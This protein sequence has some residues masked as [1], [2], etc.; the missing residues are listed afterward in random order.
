[1]LNVIAD[2]R[3][4]VSGLAEK[5]PSV[6]VSDIILVRESG[7]AESRWFEGHVH[8]VLE[9]SVYLQFNRSFHCFSGQRFDVRFALNRTTY[10]R[11]HQAMNTAYSEKRTLFPGPEEVV[12]LQPPTEE[13]WGEIRTVERMI[14]DNKPQMEAIATIV[15]RPKGSPPFVVFG[16]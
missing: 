15:N 10:R 6:I 13:Q 9:K 7:S 1:L 8:R 4:E 2:Y 14:M 3:L 11:M 16:P 12:N 5:R